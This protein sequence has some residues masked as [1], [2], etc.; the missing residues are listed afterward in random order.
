MSKVGRNDPCP[1]GSGRK[2]KQCHGIAGAPRRA[3]ADS[4]PVEKPDAV[5]LVM[6]GLQLQQADRLDEAEAMYCRALA[7]DPVQ[8]DALHLRGLL[9]HQRGESA[10]AAPWIEKAIAAR[11]GVAPYHNNCGEVYRATG[12]YEEAI[13]GTVPSP[14][15][16]PG[17]TKTRSF[18]ASSMSSDSV[19]LKLAW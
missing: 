10:Q 14:M 1:C 12:R 4:R 15:E 3:A 9:Y 11:P 17:A 7:V 2:Y 5:K 6:D 16:I 19:S 13:A 18:A 8:S